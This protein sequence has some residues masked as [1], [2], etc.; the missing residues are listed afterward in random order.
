MDRSHTRQRTVHTTLPQTRSAESQRSSAAPAKSGSRVVLVEG[1]VAR[2]GQGPGTLPGAAPARAASAKSSPAKTAGKTKRKQTVEAASAAAAPSAAPL[3]LPGLVDAS[4]LPTGDRQFAIN[5]ARGLEVLRA[6]TPTDTMLGNRDIAD[7]T[8]LPKATVSRLTY[9]L[10]LLGYLS[11]VERYQKYRLGSGV[12]SLG[13]PMLASMRVR[14]I[15]RPF[16][17]QIARDTGCTVN[18]GMRDR[19]NVVYVD[20]CRGDEG[21][22]YQPDIGSARPLL[23]TSM[24]R[25]LL[26]ASTPQERAAI[27][28]RIKVDD[29]VRFGQDQAAWEADSTRFRQYG[30][31]MSAG[32]W[33]KEV[34]AVG[35]PVRQQSRDERVAINGTMS[36]FRLR[37]GFLEKEVAPR[38]L[39][40]A[41]RI[42]QICGLH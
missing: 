5:L 27:L 16:M 8:G 33:R 30:Y 21:N 10:T 2:E 7:R 28:N 20:T 31:C 26:L 4:A 15:A 22:I 41:L 13:Y 1:S 9:T 6:F 12:L 23:C 19:L 37:K 35:V 34:H 3:S 11:H 25:A 17:E 24:G 32:D 40:A 29:L 36:A 42:E 39:E 14:Q 18:L 38:L